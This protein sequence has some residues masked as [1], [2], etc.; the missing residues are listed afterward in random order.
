MKVKAKEKSSQPL[1]QVVLCYLVK[2]D[3]VLLAMKKRGFGMGKWNG[4]GGKPQEG[5]NLEQ[6]A[7]REV[8]E[9]IGV[10]ILS[11]KKV[12][13]FDFFFPKAP[14]DKNW[15]QQVHVFLVD[16]WE[17]EPIESEEMKPQW[18]KKSELPLKDMWADDYLWLPQVLTEEKLMKGKFIFDENQQITEHL[19]EVLTDLVTI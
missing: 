17:G 10:K 19:V 6:A 3:K 7:F 9:E 16:K 5:E 14:E 11:T 15:N 2:G 4:S 12:C 13:I 18:F 1:R 8:Q